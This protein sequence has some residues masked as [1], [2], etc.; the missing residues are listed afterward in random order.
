MDESCISKT[1]NNVEYNGEMFDK[2][3]EI[4]CK[5]KFTIKS[6]TYETMYEKVNNTLVYD[7]EKSCLVCDLDVIELGDHSISFIYHKNDD[8]SR[9]SKSEIIFNTKYVI[10]NG[11][12]YPNAKIYFKYPV[13]WVSYTNSENSI[14]QHKII[15]DKWIEV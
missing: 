15:N 11:L 10:V 8:G 7:K 9:N 12:K 2:L 13:S 5:S 6:N 1:S 3:V 14:I 4:Y